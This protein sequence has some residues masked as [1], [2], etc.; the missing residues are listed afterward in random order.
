VAAAERKAA[1]YLRETLRVLLEQVRRHYLKAPGS[2]YKVYSYG[3]FEKAVDPL[4][5]PEYRKVRT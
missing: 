2:D 1:K 4:Q 5:Y 3:P